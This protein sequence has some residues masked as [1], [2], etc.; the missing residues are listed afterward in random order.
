MILPIARDVTV[1]QG[2]V[3]KVASTFEWES[4]RLSWLLLLH[5]R[6]FPEVEQTPM[7]VQFGLYRFFA[8]VLQVLD[9]SGCQ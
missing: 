8:H 5:L 4:I 6:R 2:I 3:V 1:I 9:V 7:K